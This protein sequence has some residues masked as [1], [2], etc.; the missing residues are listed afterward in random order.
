MVFNVPP[1]PWKL[2][3][4]RARPENVQ[5]TEVY[6]PSRQLGY[7]TSVTGSATELLPTSVKLA[8]VKGNVKPEN[9]PHGAGL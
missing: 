4:G 8:W 7:F 6:N 1:A 5:N 3:K 2:K 9:T